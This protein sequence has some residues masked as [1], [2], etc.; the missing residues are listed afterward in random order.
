VA[1]PRRSRRRNIVWA[2]CRSQGPDGVAAAPPD[3]VVCA[4][5]Y[6]GLGAIATK[7]GIPMTSLHRYLAPQVVDASSGT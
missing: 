5:N 1:A 4:G 2:R 7:T 3:I 6:D